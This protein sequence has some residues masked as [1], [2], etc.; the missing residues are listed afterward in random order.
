MATIAVFIALGGSSYAVT[1][2]NGKQIKNRSITGAKLKRNTLTG[3]QI[4]EAKLATVPN[5]GNAGNAGLLDNLDSPAFQRAGAAAGGALSGN[6][7][8]PSLSPG[9][10]YRAVGAAG[11][12]GFQNSWRNYGGGYTTA[13]FYKD[14]LGIVHLK[15]MITSGPQ[16]SVAF[17]LPSGYI[18][19]EHS[20]FSVAS[21]VVAS[22]QTAAVTVVSNGNVLIFNT[23]AGAD[24]VSLDGIT[25]RAP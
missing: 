13:A 23:N 14:Q 8:N 1:R 21:R 10:D 25:F 12:P 15:G 6:Y 22:P 24:P 2:V 9:E 11:Q 17:T 20:Y 5:A 3:M 19:A 16:G 7:P 4:R 18:P